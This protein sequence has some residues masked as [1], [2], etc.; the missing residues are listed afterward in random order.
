VA[1][2]AIDLHLSFWAVHPRFGQVHIVR[3]FK[4]RRGLESLAFFKPHAIKLF[5]IVGTG[6]LHAE[7]RMVT[8]KIFHIQYSC[9]CND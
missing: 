4:S 2:R 3:K 6:K 1:G 9:F 8:I 7:I 5:W